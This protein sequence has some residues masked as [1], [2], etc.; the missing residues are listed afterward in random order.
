MQETCVCWIIYPPLDRDCIVCLPESAKVAMC[1]HVCLTFMKHIAHGAVVNNHNFAQI[2]LDLSQVFN[3]GPIA[4]GAVLSIVSSCEVLAL[5]LNQ[6]N[7]WV[8]VLLHG[9][10]EDD[11]IVPLR[12]LVSIRV[13]CT[14]CI[15]DQSIPFSR[16]RN[17]VGAH[18][19]NIG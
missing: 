19:Q 14:L 17:N 8:G 1:T 16:S 18:A 6:I 3:V 7:D 12:Y 13:R 11:E 10:G 4:K 2:W 9:S 5:F 15:R